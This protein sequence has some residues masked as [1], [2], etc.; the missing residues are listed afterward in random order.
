MIKKL[1]KLLVKEPDPVSST[2]KYPGYDTT[3]FTNTIQRYKKYDIGDFT[4]GT[5]EI[6]DLEIYDD[7]AS[8]PTRLKIGRFCSIGP[9]VKIYLGCEHRT[10]WITTYPFNALNDKF[11]YIKGH[12]HSKGDVIIGNDVWLGANV[13]ILS[14]VRIGNGAVIGANAL[15]TKDVDAYSLTSGNP[16]KEIRK[17]FDEET[18]RFFQDTSWWNLDIKDIEKVV[19][20]LQSDNIEEFKRQIKNIQ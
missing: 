5:P 15:V 1:Q 3:A 9:D 4:Y 17:R 13:S 7:I 14:G 6:F 18:I 11:R 12:P 8:R 19:H 16:A 20:L 2:D 10:D